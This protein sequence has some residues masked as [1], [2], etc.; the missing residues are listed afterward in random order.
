MRVTGVIP[1]RYDSTRFPGKVLAR[2]TGKYLIEHVFERAAAANLLEEVIIATDDERV[3]DAVASFGAP[4]R[5]TSV[6]CRSG[7]D[8]VAEVA[9]SL[10]T[11]VILNIQG[12]EPEIDP[13]H[14]DR[15]AEQFLDD[16]TLE[17]ATLAT[18]IT[19]A[20]DFE[21]PNVV[22]VVINR[23]GYAMYFSRAPIPSPGM[24]GAHFSG[25]GESLFLRHIGLYGYRRDILLALSRMEE[26]ALEKLERL[27]QLRALEAGFDIKV[28]V[29]DSYA[30]GIDTPNDYMKF[31]EKQDQGTHRDR[32]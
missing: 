11:D 20:E 12:D 30:N 10:T 22:K 1:A 9:D 21:D 23:Q 32:S 15:V 3:A 24:Q 13:A 4:C 7:G 17:I 8:R 28:C 6:E 27:E 14:I 5:M 25:V 2:D 19:N 29:V 26:S 16:P 18:P 31:V